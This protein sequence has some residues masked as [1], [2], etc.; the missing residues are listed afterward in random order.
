MV[1]ATIKNER[2]LYFVLAFGDMPKI[3]EEQRLTNKKAIEKKALA[4]FLRFGYHG[5]SMRDL[6]KAADIS[7]GNIYNYYP[8]KLSLFRS[9]FESL[10]N[11]F[12]QAENPLRKYLEECDFPND[13]E[14][15]ARA[16]EANVE[17]Y[18]PYFKMTYIDVVEFNG[19]HAKKV[20]SNTKSKF[21]FLLGGHFKKVG[22]LGP[23]KN[24]DPGFAFV[25]AYF[26][27]YYFFALKKLFGAE[28]TYGD[29][30]D[31]EVVS[32]LIELYS[33]GIRSQPRRKKRRPAANR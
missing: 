8:D 7:L 21:D 25:A 13:L 15:L 22:G 5:V 26:Q 16:V 17:R 31:R 4:C 12:L 3:K 27:F 30:S 18:V 2:F 19:L 33:G 11:D 10:S 20:F 29:I 32:K 1:A 28:N 6:A 9:I 24:I 23:Q 14:A